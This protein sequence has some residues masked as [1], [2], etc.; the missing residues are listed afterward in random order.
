MGLSINDVTF[1]Q[2]RQME[3]KTTSGL[4]KNAN[5]SKMVISQPKDQRHANLH[6]GKI[7]YHSPKGDTVNFLTTRHELEI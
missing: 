4:I 5:N 6:D 7:L 2:R 3:S 1:G